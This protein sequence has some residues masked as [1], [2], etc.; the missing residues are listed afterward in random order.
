[1]IVVIASLVVVLGIVI[2]A[3]VSLPGPVPKDQVDTKGQNT[4]AIAGAA[5]TAVGALASAYFGIKAAN[6]ARE[7]SDKNAQRQTIRTAALAGAGTDDAVRQANQEATQ[8]IR[9]LGL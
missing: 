7:D 5:L 1:M 2:A 4:V 3:Y 6:A 9:S 8:Q